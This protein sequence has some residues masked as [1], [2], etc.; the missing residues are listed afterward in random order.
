MRSFAPSPSQSPS[1]PNTPVGIRNLQP[2]NDKRTSSWVPSKLLG[3]AA[4]HSH[5]G[6]P[7][8]EQ[9]TDQTTITNS[10]CRKVTFASGKFLVIDHVPPFQPLVPD[11]PA[12]EAACPPDHHFTSLQPSRSVVMLQYQIVAFAF[13][14]MLRESKPF[15]DF[16]ARTPNFRFQGRSIHNL[17]VNPVMKP[18]DILLHLTAAWNAMGQFCFANPSHLNQSR[19]EIRP[20]ASIFCVASHFTQASP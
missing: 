13:S 20:S 9:L 1:N 8:R 7:H 4:A 2:N 6:S 5:P 15:D 14:C 10:R 11:P 18:R 17:D 19:I 12:R 3:W 16:I